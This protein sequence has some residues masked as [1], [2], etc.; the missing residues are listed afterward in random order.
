MMAFLSF[1]NGSNSFSL[2]NSEVEHS[3]TFLGAVDFAAVQSQVE[4]ETKPRTNTR[5][6]EK[7]RYFIGKYSSENSN[8]ATGRKFRNQFPGIKESSIREF[9]KRYKDKLKKFK[10]E[11][12]EV[13]KTL[14][15]YP[16]G[17]KIGRP[18]HLGEFDAKL[19]NSSF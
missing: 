15:K 17:N 11:N 5:L 6:T 16:S 13:T 10:K 12:R 1:S 4:K 2:D 9:R 8:A 18:L 7:D 19:Y 3:N 14:P